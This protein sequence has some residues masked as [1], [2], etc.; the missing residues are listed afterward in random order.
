MPDSASDVAIIGAIISMAR[1]LG[2]T[3]TA[4]G[5]ETERQ[6]ELLHQM[7]CDYG[8]GWLFGAADTASALVDWFARND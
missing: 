5:I 2:V 3:I 8:Q 6:R 1:S 7:D 4:E